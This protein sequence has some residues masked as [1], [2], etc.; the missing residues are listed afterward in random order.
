MQRVRIGLLV[1]LCAGHAM[2]LAQ[3]AP[4]DHAI[5][6]SG[7]TL[8]QYLKDLDGQGLTALRII[9]GGKFNVNIHRITKAE[10]AP[11]D[12]KTVDTWVVLEGGGTLTS[13]GT[14]EHGTIANGVSNPLKAGDVVF[15]PSGLAH[16]VSGVNGNLTWLSVRWDD[17][18][19]P[20]AGPSA[21]GGAGEPV[22]HAP[23]DRAVSFRKRSWTRMAD[24]DAKNRGTLRLLEGGLFSLNIR[25][26]RRHRPSCMR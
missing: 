8:S 19:P 13:G 26:Q 4:T 12:P 6:I 21:G 16:G 14:L 11:V 2:L 3:Q 5:A 15:I 20:A 9:E 7:E 22:E 17:D 18:Y 10:T 24:M 23:K 25:R 1:A